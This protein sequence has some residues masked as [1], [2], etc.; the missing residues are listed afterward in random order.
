M[1]CTQVGGKWKQALRD[2]NGDNWEK[3][4]KAAEKA[5]AEGKPP[6]AAADGRGSRGSE[7]GGR[8]CDGSGSAGAEEVL[9]LS[10]PMRLAMETRSGEEPP[11]LEAPCAD[12]PLWCHPGWHIPPPPTE[13]REGEKKADAAAAATAAAGEALVSAMAFTFPAA[14]AAA[15]ALPTAVARDAA[16]AEVEGEADGDGGA[17]LAAVSRSA[18]EEAAGLAQPGGALQHVTP[19]KSSREADRAGPGGARPIGGGKRKRQEA[20]PLMLE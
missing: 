1:A 18:A 19:D 10:E 15:A 11:P 20:E 6:R 7:S 4:E 17:M 12:L 16:M 3:L 5:A 13:P 9:E 2:A 14:A 8:G